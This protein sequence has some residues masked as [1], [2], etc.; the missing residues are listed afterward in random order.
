[1][2]TQ[3]LSNL[4]QP[5]KINSAQINNA[6]SRDA[7]LLLSKRNASDLNRI[8]DYINLILVP[9]FGSLTSKPKYPYDT[10]ESGISGNTIVTFLETDG[11]SNR[12][13]PL[14]WKGGVT[15]EDGRPCTIKESFDYLLSVTGDRILELRSADVDLGEVWG[16]IACND[17][18][19]KQVKIETLGEKYF[20]SCNSEAYLAH[21]L[22]R[23]IKEILTQLTNN[24]NNISGD[25]D[26]GASDYPNLVL[27][28]N[29]LQNASETLRGVVEKATTR[30]VSE[31]TS[32]GGTGAG[33]F[34]S[35]DNLLAALGAD[36]SQYDNL[37]KAQLNKLTDIRISS[38]N[39]G[40]LNNVNTENA[41]SGEVLVF[42]GENWKA[43]SVTAGANLGT[44]SV[45]SSLNDVSGLVENNY[46]VIVFEKATNTNIKEE[47]YKVG[48][49]NNSYLFSEDGAYKAEESVSLR[50]KK[51][52]F[53]FRAAPMESIYNNSGI[54]LV[55]H[56]GLTKYINFHGKV[57]KG[58]LGQQARCSLYS[59]SLEKHLIEPNKIIGVSRSDIEY[60]ET[61]VGLEEGA[62]DGTVDPGFEN[63][64]Q[65]GN[66]LTIQESGTTPV[67]VVGPHKIGELIYL[68]P[69]R[70]LEMLGIKN[71]VGLAISES[72]FETS[73]SVLSK[74]SA[75]SSLTL[76][77]LFL[78][79]R[80]QTYLTSLNELEIKS[81]PL[82]V[83]LNK[84]DTEDY[85]FNN[86]GSEIIH[87]ICYSLLESDPISGGNELSN[88][89][90]Q[91]LSEIIEDAGFLNNL[92]FIQ[93]LANNKKISLPIVKLL[94]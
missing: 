22:S 20:L 34:V 45:I 87:N 39:I 86:P 91:E 83:I 80:S 28:S 6:A 44:D 37:L 19:I 89:V 38:S 85:N 8:A 67:M 72:F 55:N 25:L 23:H 17:R 36:S 13:S 84:T 1:M 52:P 73:I 92:D 3:Y 90:I 56:V 68:C 81:K 76:M 70:I 58:A 82:G 63:F 74:N 93:M 21:S 16:Q 41:S 71:G 64:I 5:V 10:I 62:P 61:W 24:P 40:L 94:V 48:G 12:N 50:R 31:G 4:N 9:A 27:N 77:D 88:Y 49:L 79:E 14:Y 35:P 42:D 54:N 26:V 75:P 11:N 32:S 69:E 7:L 47:S 33:L 65:Q 78:R 46:E 53:V 2:A 59:E 15:P 57:T 51:I 18:K 30:E 43:D 29:L 66:M 60:G